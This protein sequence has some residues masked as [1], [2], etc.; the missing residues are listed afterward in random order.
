M[1]KELYQLLQREQ[2][3][4]MVKIRSNHETEF[5]NSKFYEYRALEGISHKISS[6]FTPQQ[7][8]MV[9]RNNK[10]LQHSAKVILHAKKLPYYFWAKAMTT[11]CHIHNKVVIYLELKKLYELWKGRNPN[12]KY[13]R[14]FGRRCYI[15]PDRDQRRKWILRVMK[16]PSLDTL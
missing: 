16:E 7:N 11:T 14:V 9:E 10:T 5:E 1:F 12:V 6:H 13:L 4:R 15:L 2:N 3:I 8:G